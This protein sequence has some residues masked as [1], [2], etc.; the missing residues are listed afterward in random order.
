MSEIEEEYLRLKN[1]LDDQTNRIKTKQLSIDQELN[2]LIVRIND[3]T[4]L[5]WFFVWLGLAIVIFAI[6]VY[7]NQDTESGFSLNLLG[8]FMS[9]TVSATWSLAGLFFIYVAFLGQ[10][11]QLLTQQLELMYSQLELKY[12]RLELHGQKQEMIDQNNTLK[13]Q[14]FENSFFQLLNLLNS[15][16]KS[17]SFVIGSDENKVYGK[18]CMTRIWRNVNIAFQIHS[19]AKAKVIEEISIETV[20]S[21]FWF[22]NEAYR[23]TLDHYSRVIENLFNFIDNADIYDKNNYIS[24]TID[25]LSSDE[26]LI[27]FYF[28]LCSTN[29]NKLKE[30]IEKHSVFRN[31]NK[32]NLFNSN[33]LVEYKKSAY[34]LN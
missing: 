14:R 5:A 12:T 22:Y 16:L 6:V 10:K 3:Y 31:L 19:S 21:N 4:K 7:C 32:G 30:I 25:Q 29:K 34:D 17:F 23:E 1:D 20:K 8:D 28:I 15:V 2:K 11:Q 24:I 13:H 27:L 26:L 33:H 18:E 9:G